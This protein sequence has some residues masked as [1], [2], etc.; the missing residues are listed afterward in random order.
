MDYDQSNREI[1]AWLKFTGFWELKKWA[2][3]FMSRKKET[4]QGVEI[5]G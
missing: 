1:L 2:D 5:F 4:N 3:S